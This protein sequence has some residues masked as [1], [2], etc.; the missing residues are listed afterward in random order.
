MTDTETSSTP[1]TIGVVKE[2]KPDERRVALVPK[3]VERLTRR[4]LRVVV[5][6]GAGA[7]A[8][9]S[10][11]LF[12]DAGATVGDAWN[13]DVVLKVAPPT[14][15]EIERLSRGT[16]L[17]GFL[18]PLTNV[19]EVA[20]LKQAGIRAFAVESIP[21][22]S[23]AQAMDALSSQANVAGYR[24]VLL[25]AQRLPKFFPMLTTA[26]GTVPPAKALVLGAGVAGLQA[27]ATAK[28]LGAQ[29]TGY[30]VRPEVAEQVKSVGA[31]WLDLGIEAVG[32]GGYA[33]ELTEDERAEQQRRLT[34]AITEFDVVIT[35]ALVPGRKAPTLVTADAVRGMRPGSVV[36]DM[37]G[38]S[39]GNCELTEPGTD[40]V[41]HDVT[42]CSPLNLPA[43][44]PVHASELYARNLTELLEL[45]VDSE[46]RLALDF[47]D[48]IV[49]GACVAGADEEVN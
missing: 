47:S 5:E 33:R 46:G 19:E 15:S 35:T 1:L 14:T 3:L 11:E 28:R 38:E 34:E 6:P 17:I 24:A 12:T 45:M 25:A 36:V 43:E 22:I 20:A 40:V 39:G 23:R 32:E 44:M 26:A 31:Q 8:Q 16:V 29:P 48:E 21:R 9:L 49:A 13:A 2:T 10:D 7:A 30:D 18:A 42:I 4:G 27:L 41:V 37:A